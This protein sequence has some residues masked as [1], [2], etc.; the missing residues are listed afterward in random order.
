M[1]KWVGHYNMISFDINLLHAL[2]PINVPK[3]K[4]QKKKKSF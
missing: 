4:K 1:H 3:N 2:Q